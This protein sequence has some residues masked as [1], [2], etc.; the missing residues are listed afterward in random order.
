MMKMLKNLD[1]YSVNKNGRMAMKIVLT[2]ITTS[3]LVLLVRV[4][5]IILKAIKIASVDGLSSVHDYVNIVM[6][7]SKIFK[8][9]TV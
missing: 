9:I 6:F 7:S 3:G 1:W 8:N 2:L 4:Q 5:G